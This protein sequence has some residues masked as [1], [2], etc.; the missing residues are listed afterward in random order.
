MQSA[1]EKCINCKLTSS[2]L[3]KE[4]RVLIWSMMVW[5]IAS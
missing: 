1:P 2:K 3:G 4:E 5:K